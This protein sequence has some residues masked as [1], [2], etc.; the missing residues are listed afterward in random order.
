[1]LRRKHAYAGAALLLAAGL[2]YPSVA[3]WYFGSSFEGVIRKNF[4]VDP[5][6]PPSENYGPGSLYVVGYDGNIE[7]IVCNAADFIDQ[8]TIGRVPDVSEVAVFDS[9]ADVGSRIF[10]SLS[11]N[12][13]TNSARKVRVVMSNARIYEFDDATRIDVFGKLTS[14]EFCR[15]AIVHA[16]NDGFCVSQSYK[17]LLATGDIRVVDER[18]AQI[19]SPEVKSQVKEKLQLQIAS[20]FDGKTSATINQTL[21]GEEIY[22]GFRLYE[23]CIEK[24]DA[25]Y[26]RTTPNT[27]WWHVIALRNAAKSMWAGLVN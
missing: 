10:G 17:S 15:E 7:R 14:N 12:A 8:A 5:M 9:D 6:V 22:F 20:E 13:G 24:A 16:Q 11:A 18:G 2:A 23:R 25:T 4:D 27:R 26:I 1:M 21:T 19:A 3:A